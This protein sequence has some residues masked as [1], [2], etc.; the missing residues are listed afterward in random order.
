VAIFNLTMNADI[1]AGGAANDI[2]RG[3]GGG[4]DRLNGGAGA[5][6]FFLQ[7]NQQGRIDGGIGIDSIIMRGDLNGTFMRNLTFVNVEQLFA[8]E[9]RLFATA[10]QLSSF[11]RIVPETDEDQF[12]IFLG[13]PGG[14]LDLSQRY[15]STTALRVDAFGTESAVTLIGS[16]RGDSLG[17]SNFNDVIVGGLGKDGLEGNGGNDVFRY[18]AVNQSPRGAGADVIFNFDN[19]D[20]DRINLSALQGPALVYRHSA[21]FT[22]TGQVRIQDVAGPDVVVQVNLTGTLTPEMEIRLAFVD[23]PEMSKGDFIL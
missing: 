1:H 21:P 3:P 18:A 8:G 4:I 19:F 7:P 23:L 15:T 20:D 5:D 14:A 11:T 10:S 22:K 9:P 13:G 17:G 12:I 2:F 6:R 16:A